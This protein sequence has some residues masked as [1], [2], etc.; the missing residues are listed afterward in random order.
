VAKETTGNYRQPVAVLVRSIDAA[1]LQ[2]K[3]GYQ[4][5]YATGYAHEL[6]CADKAK[7]EFPALTESEQLMRRGVYWLWVEHDNAKTDP[8]QV[9]LSLTNDNKM[10]VDIVVPW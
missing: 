4:V 5:F 3:P 2:P 6:G 8:K 7:H 9:D 10:E 1:S